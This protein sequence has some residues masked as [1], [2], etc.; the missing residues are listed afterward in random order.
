MNIP[1][2]NVDYLTAP[3]DD[4]TLNTGRNNTKLKSVMFRKKIWNS[5]T[6]AYEKEIT[7]RCSEFTMEEEYNGIL[8][9]DFL[10]RT[11]NPS[12]K[13]GAPKLKA[14]LK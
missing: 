2:Y 3:V 11:I 10:R 13:V 5:L 6:S 14:D 12:T 1:K 9:I 7:G 8:L 4:Q